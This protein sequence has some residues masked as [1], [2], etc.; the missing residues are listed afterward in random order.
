MTEIKKKVGAGI[1]V[2][3]LNKEGQVLLGKRHDDPE[4]ADSE[5]HG[6]GCWTMP[7][8]KLEFGETFEEGG[9]REV[10][11]E[12]GIVVKGLIVISLHND[13]NEHAHFVT[14]GMM[15]TKFKGEPNVMEPDEIVEWRWFDLKSL[16]TP[17]FFPSAKVVENYL[18]KE[19]YLGN[20]VSSSL[21]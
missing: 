14:I 1:G 2:M 15:A 3:I 18:A 21:L 20:S 11:E 13:K 17:M 5:L 19:F 8:G 16:P 9:A 10:K 12:T 6:E 7:G 4:K